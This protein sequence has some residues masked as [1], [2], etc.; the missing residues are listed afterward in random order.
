M[1]SV[2]DHGRGAGFIKRPHIAAALVAG[3]GEF[4]GRRQEHDAAAAARDQG[5]GGAIGEIVIGGVDEGVL[6]REFRLAEGDEGKT[7]LQHELDAHVLWLGMGE[8][9]PV[10]G[11]GLDDVAN[12]HHRI[13]VD[14]LRQDLEMVIG[15]AQAFA[16]THDQAFGIVAHV[17]GLVED[18]GDDEGLAGLETHAGAM[19]KVADLI[20]DIADPLLGAQAQLRPVLQSARHRRHAEPRQ[21]GDRLEGRARISGH[22]DHRSCR[23]LA[24]P[25]AVTA[26]LQILPEIWAARVSTPFV[27]RDFKRFF[28]LLPLLDR[29]TARV[30]NVTG[31]RRSNR[32]LGR[33]NA[34]RRLPLPSLRSC[35]KVSSR[36]RRAT[37]SQEVKWRA[38]LPDQGPV[39]NAAGPIATKGG[40]LNVAQVPTDNC[41]RV[42]LR[43][44]RQCRRAGR[45]PAL[46]DVG[47]RGRGARRAQEEPRKPGRHLEG[48][49]GRRRRRRGRR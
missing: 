33:Y 1:Q 21:F 40:L 41:L 26:T 3:I 16:D 44:G 5:A 43:A 19:G 14:I 30:C 46:V 27:C 2:G 47:R 4:G 42:R 22:F 45:G 31:A 18:E 25:A 20:G 32:F 11:R 12:R 34:L 10:G 29:L 8:D 23:R 17:V 9:E 48:H 15:A 28:R 36:H 6:A 24:A 7:A 13:L 37:R 38:L 39:A 49:A 35:A